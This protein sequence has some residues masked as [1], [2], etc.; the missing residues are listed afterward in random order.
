[1]TGQTRE[2]QGGRPQRQ[3]THH[4]RHGGPLS[5]KVRLWGRLSYET[6]TPG[7]RPGGLHLLVDGAYLLGALAR[8]VAGI[9]AGH[10]LDP[11]PLA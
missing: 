10:E 2:R 11:L 8:R 4:D 7:T 9:V 6:F 1:M 3:R 5:V